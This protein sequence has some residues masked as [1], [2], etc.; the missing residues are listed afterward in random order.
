[1][2]ILFDATTASFGV[3]GLTTYIPSL[4]GS[5]AKVAP[6]DEFITLINHDAPEETRLAAE[7][8]GTVK[9]IGRRGLAYRLAVQQCFVPY[10]LR[11]PAAPNVLL[12]AAPDFPVAASFRVPAVTVVHD[13]RHLSQPHQF[14]RLQGA[15]RRVA[16]RQSYRRSNRLVAISGATANALKSAYPE[17]ANKISVV[18]HG[19]DHTDRWPKVRKQNLALA[20]G[21]WANKRPDLAV[22]VWADLRQ[23]INSF[24]WTLHIV[25]VPDRA[26]KALLDLSNQL[27]VAD[28]TRIHAFLPP[29][30]FQE[31][32]AASQLMLFPTTEEGFGL[33]IVEAMRL[34]IPVVTSDIPA[35]REVGG[36]WALYADTSSQADLVESCF[37]AITDHTLRAR[38]IE[39]GKTW[40][41]Q[42]SWQRTAAETRAVL[43]N[44]LG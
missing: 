41:S 4:L 5:W 25:G 6:D 30:P 42:F 39:G 2:R 28:L 22:R 10:L 8:V 29:A 34:G 1:L 27:Q 33:P 24:D 36:E 9:V 32:F 12:A 21:Q 17:T 26:T 44:A 3:G 18:H 14:G 31:L 35:A 43:E 11:K 40:S 20:F 7:A 13:M 19:A 16:Y 37:G 23:R 38:L 15:Y